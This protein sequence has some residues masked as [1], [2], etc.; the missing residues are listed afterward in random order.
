MPIRALMIELVATRRPAVAVDQRNARE[1]AAADED[2][3][4]GAASGG[5][6]ANVLFLITVLGALDPRG[7][8]GL[9]PAPLATAL[10]STPAGHLAVNERASG[11]GPAR[12][13]SPGHAVAHR[14]SER[15]GDR[16]AHARKG[17][18]MKVKSGCLGSASCA[19]VAAG[20]GD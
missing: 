9:R 10:A 14:K 3:T 19:R 15:V 2:G 17:R 18:R 1:H 13:A 8:A 5:L 12:T 6:L 4:A 16:P 11:C 20:A 7:Q